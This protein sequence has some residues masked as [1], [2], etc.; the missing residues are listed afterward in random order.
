MEH[1]SCVPTYI[2][3]FKAIH[4]LVLI[5][6]FILTQVRAYILLSNP[7]LLEYDEQF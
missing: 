1:I 5:K 4:A 3:T 6:L 2:S 7:H